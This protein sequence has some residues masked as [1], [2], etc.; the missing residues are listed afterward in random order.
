MPD[1]LLGVEVPCVEGVEQLQS[2]N[3]AAVVQGCDDVPADLYGEG[4]SKSCEWCD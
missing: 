4:Y 2:S 3:D 1:L